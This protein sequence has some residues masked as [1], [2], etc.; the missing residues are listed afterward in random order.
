MSIIQF[1]TVL[2]SFLVFQST[3][4]SK[5]SFE[6]LR[7]CIDE[8]PYNN[9][10]AIS[11]RDNGSYA[12]NHEKNCEEPFEVNFDNKI[13]GT[14]RCNDKFYLVVNNHKINLEKAENMSVNPEIKPGIVY[15]TDTS[16]LKIDFKNQSFLCLNGPISRAGAGSNIGQYYII[17]NAFINKVTPTIYY[18]FFDKDIIPITSEHF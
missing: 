6:V 10:V 3:S 13:F 1:I 11:S 7:S 14:V 16:W 4:F 15:P 2:V 12:E 5:P 17:E 18:Y 8:K 9:N